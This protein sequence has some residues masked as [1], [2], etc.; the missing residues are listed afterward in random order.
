MNILENL[1]QLNV[2]EEC[3]NDILNIVEDLLHDTKAIRRNAEKEAKRLGVDNRRLL[4]ISS[5]TGKRL[6]KR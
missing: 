2:S 6:Q 5:K 4:E 3:F 1:E